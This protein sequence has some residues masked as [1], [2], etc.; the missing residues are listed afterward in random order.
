MVSYCLIEEVWPWRVTVL[1]REHGDG[2][3]QHGHGELLSY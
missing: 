1:L 3:L 2:E